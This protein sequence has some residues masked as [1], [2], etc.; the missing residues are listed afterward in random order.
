M[1]V[2]VDEPPLVLLDQPLDLDRLGQHRG[3]DAHE[4]DAAVE[5][6]LGLVAQIDAERADGAAVEQNRHAD[7]AQLLV[8]AL[9]P[10]GRAIQHRRLAAHPRHDNR[11]AGLDH[12]SRN[13]FADAVLHRL[14]RPVQSVRG[15]DEQLAALAQ[16]DDHAPHGAVMPRQ[17]F[18]DAVE[19]RF[20]IESARECLTDFK[21][22]RQ[23]ARF[24]SL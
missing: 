8:V 7:E 9:G 21:Q 11:L 14:R 24:A 12:P 4:L 20:A 2:L 10:S 23:P 17:D 5:V 3:D 18:E 13:T 1:L 16:H 22:R 15:L 19:C 6:A